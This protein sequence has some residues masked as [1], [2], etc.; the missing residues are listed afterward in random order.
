MSRHCA[1][2]DRHRAD[3]GDSRGSNTSTLALFALFTIVQCLDA[4]LTWRGIGRFGVAIEANP[5]LSFSA[6]H[7][8]TGATLGAAKAVAVSCALVLHLR[9]YRL[10]LSLLTLFYVLSAIVPWTWVLA[11]S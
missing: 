11:S 7:F 9:S 1:E 6:A 5:L 2:R 10:V 4:V 8:G 3:A